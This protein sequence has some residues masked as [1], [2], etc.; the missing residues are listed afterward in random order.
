MCDNLTDPG[1]RQ[2]HPSTHPS[3]GRAPTLALRKYSVLADCSK[4]MPTHTTAPATARSSSRRSNTSSGVMQSP[5]SSS[6]SITCMTQHGRSTAVSMADQAHLQC[7]CCHQQHPMSCCASGASIVRHS[8]PTLCCSLPALGTYLEAHLI[9]VACLAQHR[10]TGLHC[11][12]D[13]ACQRLHGVAGG[14]HH[15]AAAARPNT[16]STH[17]AQLSWHSSPLTTRPHSQE[18]SH[19]RN[20]CVAVAACAGMADLMLPCISTVLPS[21]LCSWCHVSM[22]TA[23]T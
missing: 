22:P 16:H 3:S 17:T 23:C 2:P 12:H 10:L 9:L 20:P 7:D 18:T 1:Q 19:C 14:A 21:G 11:L 8:T 4:L 6:Y 15:V 5:C 13:L